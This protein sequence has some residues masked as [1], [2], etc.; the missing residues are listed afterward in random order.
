MLFSQC[1]CFVSASCIRPLL[2]SASCSHFTSML[3]GI[4]SVSIKRSR[5][6]I[7]RA[8]RVEERQTRAEGSRSGYVN[9]ARK[10]RRAV[11]RG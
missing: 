7:V 10:G 1:L 3:A 9:R 11:Q 4:S 8:G 6:G 5:K 2:T